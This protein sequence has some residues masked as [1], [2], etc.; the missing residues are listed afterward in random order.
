MLIR[1]V[2]YSGLSE[3]QSC[4]V[5]TPGLSDSSC[6]LPEGRSWGL[7]MF[8]SSELEPK[9]PSI[10]V[11]S[12][13]GQSGHTLVWRL[14]FRS[15]MDLGLVSFRGGWWEVLLARVPWWGLGCSYGLQKETLIA[16]Y[17]W[18]VL[19]AC[20]KTINWISRCLAVAAM[21]LGHL[22]HAFPITHE[23]LCQAQK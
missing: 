9:S 22:K 17:P 10:N 19:Y 2:S 6:E 7:F 11:D 12:T 8:A 21:P 15:G 16:S 4:V 3:M 23:F 20:F 13:P 1:T 18:W 5:W 14:H